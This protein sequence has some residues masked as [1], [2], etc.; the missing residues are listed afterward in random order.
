MKAI[1][2]LMAVLLL[3]ALVACNAKQENANKESQHSQDNRVGQEDNVREMTGF[4]EKI[5]KEGAVPLH[6]L[7]ALMVKQDSLN[8][9]LTGEIVEVC[10]KKGCWMV[11]DLGDGHL[12]R[13]TFRDYMFFVPQDI[14]GRKAVVSGTA[15]K[16]TTSVDRLRHYAED[17]GKSPAEVEAIQ[18]PKEEV[19]FIADGV[20]LE[21]KEI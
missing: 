8:I 17:A 15:K 13:V 6:T 2:L 21:Q 12:M 16:E 3:A 14:V 5:N 19:V 20:L 9:K 10:R 11:M 4:G 1:G 18:S 7:S